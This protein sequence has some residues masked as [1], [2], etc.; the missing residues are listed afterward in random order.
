MES[1]TGGK[2]K[3]L[4]ALRPEPKKIWKV[5]RKRTFKGGKRKPMKWAIH[6]D[7]SFL[8]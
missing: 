3:P 5:P 6:I 8:T 2:E 7:L 4:L 1:Q